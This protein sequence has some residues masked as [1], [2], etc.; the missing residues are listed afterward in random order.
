MP[1]KSE[2]SSLLPR[3]PSPAL[4]PGRQIG[5]GPTRLR[6]AHQPALRF[7][8]FTLHPRRLSAVLVYRNART[9][10]QGEHPFKSKPGLF[11]DLRNKGIR[12]RH[13]PTVPRAAPRPLLGAHVEQD[14]YGGRRAARGTACQEGPAWAGTKL[15]R[16]LHRSIFLRVQQK[17]NPC[18]RK[19]SSRTPPPPNIL[20]GTE[21]E[22]VPEEIP[23]DAHSR[24]PSSVRP[25]ITL[26]P[27][28]RPGFTH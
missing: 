1:R 19:A 3:P 23:K 26:R 12:P 25:A 18:T 15:L 5:H 21:S 4:L 10:T 27:A 9:I 16:L 22:E 11:L 24:N 20:R 14:S 28:P 8:R 17:I 13:L 7:A 6:H 2:P